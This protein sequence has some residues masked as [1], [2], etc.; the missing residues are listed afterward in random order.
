[1]NSILE[2][3]Q[4]KM[5]GEVLHHRIFPM[6]PS[7]CRVF[8]YLF[9]GTEGKSSEEIANL[10]RLCRSG[11]ELLDTDIQSLNIDFGDILF[12]WEKHSEFSTYSWVITHSLDSL[13]VHPEDAGVPKHWL[14]DVPGELFR[15]SQ[16]RLMT[17]DDK[18]PSDQYEKYFEPQSCVRSRLAGGQAEI[19]TD[20][21]LHEE[22]AGRTLLLDHGLH[23][24]SRGRLLQQILDVGNYRRMALLGWPLT[25]ETLRNLD[26]I[27]ARH[28]VISKKIES[29]EEDD[30]SLLEDIVALS[31]RSEAM[32]AN[33]C[34]RLHATLA[35]YQ[36]T[37]DRLES[38][39]EQP[40]DGF[41]TLRNFT[42]RRLK[43]A[44]RTAESVLFRQRELA[45]RLGRSSDLIRTR[46]NHKLE[47]QNQ[48]L[49]QS[50]DDSAR[51]QVN[52]QRLV[53]L[54]SLIAVSYYLIDFVHFLFV[55]W[56]H[57]DSRI[58]PEI[59]RAAA[60]PVV[61]LMTV[62]GLYWLRYRRQAGGKKSGGKKSRGK[63]D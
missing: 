22:G 8:Q 7:P 46:S 34:S 38:I 37:V 18:S 39:K 51:T 28:A 57:L 42:D 4:R 31:A 16:I 32:F 27:E 23:P 33:N 11:D 1:M 59:G 14:A 15:L 58:D 53:E 48:S 19:W 26:D 12:R 6:L 29:R 5:I 45:S 41:L 47:R 43:P 25:Q 13:F 44:I 55:G 61:M 10:N 3:P 60:I 50:I 63:N 56:S 21:R 17:S 36:M 54:V 24:Q 9:T 52:L 62:T 30:Q 35:Y 40:V 2:H 49:L 20:F